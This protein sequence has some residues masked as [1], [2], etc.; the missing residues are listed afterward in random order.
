MTRQRQLKALIRSRMDRTG[1]TYM[2][3]RRHVLNARTDS[4]YELRGG[5][6]P[7]VASLANAFANRGITDPATGEPISEALVLG[8]GGGLGA[9]YILWEFSHYKGGPRRAVTL[10]FRNQWQY[11]D[12]WMVKVCQRLGIEAHVH[13]TAGTAKAQAQLDDALESGIPAVAFVSTA[14]LP[15]WHLPADQSGRA[16]QPITVYGKVGDRYL[17]DDRNRARLT[18]GAEELAEAR[19]RIPSYKNRLVVADPAATELEAER[20]TAAVRE[21]LEEQVAHLSA[22]SASFSLPAFDKWAR[23][24]TDSRNAKS[25]PNVFAD[26]DVVEA[27]ASVVE[28]VDDGCMWGGTLRRQYAAFLADAGRIL[29]AD[30]SDAARAYETAAD[31]WAE[32]AAVCRTVPAVDEAARLGLK[33][34]EAVARGDAGDR[35]AKAASASLESLLG[36]AGPLPPDAIARLF[37]D[38]SEALRAAVSA[39]REALETLRSLV[40]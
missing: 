3:A 33:R 30:F 20:L 10:G 4:E 2:V 12:R 25:W 19:A 35:S 29:D 18:I 32:V 13:E 23:T 26:G 21:G 36:S 16:G 8:V 6:N 7:E 31:R 9:G 40:G 15:H 17:I 24:L 28:Q 37:G 39:E 14:D 34:R 5:L 27:L 38:L 11:P 22:K 1:E